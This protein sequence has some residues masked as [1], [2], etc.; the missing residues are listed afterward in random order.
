M[1]T[2]MENLL[3]DVLPQHNGWKRYVHALTVATNR[4]SLTLSDTVACKACGE[5]NRHCGN[6]EV[7]RFSMTGDNEVM[8]VAIEEYLMAYAKHY[9][10]AQGC[11]CDYLHY[12]NG[13]TRVVLNELTCSQEK[14]VNPY[15][16]QMGRQDGKRIHAMKQM[17]NVVGLLMEVPNIAALVNGFTDKHCLFSWRIPERNVNVAEQAM[18]AFM[19][20]Q[21]N[22]ANITIMNPMNSGFLF[23][24]QIYPCEYRF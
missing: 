2:S 3:L 13:G 6:E 14:F 24:Q 12:D 18:N 1:M 4:L 21:R 17:D 16:N 15:Q 22:V 20:P 19:A 8:S 7:A 9:Q 5:R 11:K 23:V 10:K